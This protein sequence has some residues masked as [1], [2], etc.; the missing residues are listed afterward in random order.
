M[1]LAAGEQ[2]DIRPAELQPD[3]DRLAFADDDVGAHLA[4]RADQPE[5]DRLGDHRDQQRALGM[6][7]LGDRRQVGDPAEDVGILD[8]DRAGLAVDGGDQPLRVGLGG[9]LRQR[10]SSVSPVNRAMVLAT[11]T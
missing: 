2:A 9:Q 5:R 3:A 6:R 7:R 8:D 4:G 10:V 11:L 1:L